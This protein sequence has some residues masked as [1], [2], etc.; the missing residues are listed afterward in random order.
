MMFFV[1]FRSTQHITQFHDYI[2]T[3]STRLQFTVERE[4]AD[5]ALPFLD[6]HIRRCGTS[7]STAVYRKPTHTGRYTHFADFIFRDIGQT[8]AGEHTQNQSATLLQRR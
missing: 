3:F 6:V 2:N 5:C 8:G 4:N 1:I 7:V